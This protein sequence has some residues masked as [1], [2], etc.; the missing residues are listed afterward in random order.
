MNVNDDGG[1]IY[2]GGGVEVTETV[3]RARSLRNQYPG[4]CT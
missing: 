4:I 2:S 3:D 1:V